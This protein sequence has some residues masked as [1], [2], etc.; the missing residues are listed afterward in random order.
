MGGLSGITTANGWLIAVLG[1]SVVFTGLASLTLMLLYFPRVIDWMKAQSPKPLVPWLKSLFYQGE[2]K[3][4]ISI[5]PGEILEK[6]QI[7]DEEEAL[8]LL[9]VYLGEP[10]KLPQLLEVAER[11]GLAR[12]HST[13]NRLLLEGRI[14]LP[15]E[16]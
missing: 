5:G 12:P 16:N 15:P 8:H 9:S 2:R 4:P 3:A 11:R 1:I 13:I 14:D 6:G 7:E 10:F